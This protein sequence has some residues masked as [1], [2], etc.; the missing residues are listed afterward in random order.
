MTHRALRVVLL[1]ALVL[2]LLVLALPDDQ[3][4]TSP[5]P[6]TQVRM[7]RIVEDV[8]GETEG[9]RARPA[10][11]PRGNIPRAGRVDNDVL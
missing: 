11:V 8:A 10:Q 5:A 3:P 9:R 2:P 1:A 4:A 6:M 7:E